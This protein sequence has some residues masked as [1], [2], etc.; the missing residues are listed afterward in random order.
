VHLPSLQKTFGRYGASW[1]SAGPRFQ[2]GLY[3]AGTYSVVKE[4]VNTYMRIG[5]GLGGVGVGS[6]LSFLVCVLGVLMI[7]VVPT[8][9]FTVFD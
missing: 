6:V 9:E 8:S 3:E 4:Q 1:P 5:I 7:V 2:F